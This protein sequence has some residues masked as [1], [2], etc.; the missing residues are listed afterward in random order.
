MRIRGF[1]HDPQMMDAI[2][3]AFNLVV[4]MRNDFAQ[5]RGKP[6]VNGL[7]VLMHGRIFTALAF[8]QDGA[9]VP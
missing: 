2:V 1:G 7:C 4:L 3:S 9:I 5:R 6:V 8:G